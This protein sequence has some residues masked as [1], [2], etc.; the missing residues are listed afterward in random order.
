MLTIGREG[1]KHGFETETQEIMSTYTKRVIEAEIL[2]RDQGCP[3]HPL[4]GRERG[5][6]MTQR[7]RKS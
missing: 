4:E 7:L 2:N 3:E 5:S 6:D 1:K